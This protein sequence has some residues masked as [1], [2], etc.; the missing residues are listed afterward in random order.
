MQRNIGFLLGMLVF[1]GLALWAQ[2]DPLQGLWE[3]KVKSQRG[4][5]AARVTFTKAG[6]EYTGT[7][8]GPTGTGEFP[9]KEVKLDGNKVSAR[10]EFQTQRGPTT[11]TFRFNLKG[12]S[13]KGKGEVAMGR[14]QM[15]FDYELNRTS[16]TVPGA[17]TAAVSA[18]P[19]IGQAGSQAEL[20]EFNKMR[21]EADAA[22]KSRLIDDFLKKY[23]ESGLVAHAHQEA[24][25]LAQQANDI[26]KM[27]QHGEKSLSIMTDNYSLITLLA[28]AYA[29]RNL[30]DKAEEKA[31]RAIEVL[32]EAQKP[33]HVTE[34]QW[35]KGKNMMMATNFSTLG[36]VHVRRA[37]S[38]EG[39]EKRQ[40]AEKAIAPFK[41]ALEF[42]KTDD[43][44]L[45][46]LGIAY[47]YLNDYNNAESNLAKAVAVNGVASANARSL[48]EDIYK[49][50]HKN[51]LEGLDQVIA[52]AKS[53]LGLP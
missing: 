26:D 42:A 28:N 48:L 6:N 10:V 33:T 18:K 30:V 25:Y 40:H 31:E 43:I 8:S 16:E 38:K 1:S 17:V 39:A 11:V 9:F 52:K 21:T 15:E 3:G 36:Y 13:L 27:A 20:D 4:E 44:S 41:K 7:I 14:Q 23:P 49:Q 22:V 2:K 24:A 46:R 12:E 53:E 29:E 32:A 51:S 34:D 37:A 47:V 5:L 45:W 50:S 19:E 35:T